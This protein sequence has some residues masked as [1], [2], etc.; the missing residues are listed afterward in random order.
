MADIDKIEAT[1]EELLKLIKT[2]TKRI[3]KLEAMVK[4]HE[5]VRRR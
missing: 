1:I 4:F 5:Q 3:E 2:L